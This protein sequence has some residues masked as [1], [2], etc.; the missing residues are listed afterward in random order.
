VY[1]SRNESTPALNNRAVNLLGACALA[2]SDA[3]SAACD[4]QLGRSGDSSATALVA[5]LTFRSLTIEQLASSLDLSHSG[6]SRCVDR[7]EDRAWVTRRVGDPTGLGDRRSVS[8]SLT[9]AG[10]RAAQ[11]VL[12][13]RRGAIERILSPLTSAEQTALGDLLAEVMAAQIADRATLRRVCRACD[14]VV[15]EPCPALTNVERVGQLAAE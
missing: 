5:L 12:S 9:E 13:V 2:V 3:W 15:C 10:V 14:H 7:L 4:A 8:V 1:E 6:A 11:E